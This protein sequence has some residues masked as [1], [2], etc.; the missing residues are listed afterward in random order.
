MRWR[1][2]GRSFT[3]PCG[4]GNYKVLMDQYRLV[5]DVFLM[6]KPQY[7]RV[8]ADITRRMGAGM[9]EFIPKEVLLSPG[10]CCRLHNALHAPL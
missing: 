2:W 3:Y 7:Q 4:T 9:A 8:I 5:T 6:L 1:W 10:S